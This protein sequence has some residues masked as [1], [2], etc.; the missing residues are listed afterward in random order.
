MR[1]VWRKLGLAAVG[2]A[3]LVALVS[4]PSPS[5]RPLPP[6]SPF[7]SNDHSRF[8]TVRHGIATGDVTSRSALIWWRT[9]G[10]ARVKIEWWPESPD[11]GLAS[12]TE[13]GRE[14]SEQ[15]VGSTVLQT[16]EEHDFANTLSLDGLVP[17]TR[18]RYRISPEHGRLMEANPGLE[19]PASGQFT[20]APAPSHHE[21]VTLVWG[22]DLGGQE[23]CRSLGDRSGK[24]YRIFDRMR[25]VEPSFGILLGDL[26]YAD[27]RC[28]TPPNLP[29]SD[30]VATTLNEFRTKHR[31][32]RGDLALQ[33][34]LAS[35]PVYV[36]WD[37]HEVR[38]DFSG[39][40]DPLMPLGRRAL[41]EYWPI[42]TP[43]EDPHRLFRQVVYGADLELF[44]LDTR[45]YRSPNRQLDGPRKT[46]LGPKQ[47]AWLL[48]GL[49]KS[50]ATWKVIATS[51]PLSTRKPGALLGGGMD[52][53][54][55]GQDGTG[56]QR[57][58]QDIV[59]HIVARR[60]HNVIWLAG[61]VHFAQVN[62]YD[63]NKDGLT[64]FYEFICGPLSA[65][66]RK[67]APPQGDLNPTT[68]Y[69]GGGFLNFGLVTID[70]S[71]MAVTIIDDTG[72]VR[73]QRAFPA[74][75]G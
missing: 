12:L 54:V 60:I 17:A 63:P 65:G 35:V 11:P 31:Y 59:N 16:S 70:R 24:S 57:E 58:L 52:G 10:P 40:E 67:P 3:L 28:P 18:Y 47:Y 41:L 38:N 14:P 6:G 44:V 42:S 71:S 61:D 30:F 49:T 4:C 33:R 62:S 15:H 5:R 75:S 7:A 74:Q 26:I 9:E 13:P 50:T 37:D 39:L 51:V 55:R 22:G 66:T 21:P 36:I 27:G 29:G 32:Q 48:D 45:Q 68:L 73:F 64:D 23:R 20:T 2:S 46:M 19:A 1:N 43:P 34:F 69:S 8:S 53:W 56:F 25:Q 72:S